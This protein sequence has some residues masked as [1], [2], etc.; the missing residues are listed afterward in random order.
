MLKKPLT[1]TPPDFRRLPTVVKQ[2]G[3]SAASIYR[4]AKAGKFPSPIK[5]APRASAWIGAEVDGY[6]AARIAIRSGG[7][8][9]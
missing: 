6:I 7:E 8:C 2:T 4:L 9:S 5:I 1:F 3:L